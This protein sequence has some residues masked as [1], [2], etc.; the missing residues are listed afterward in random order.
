MRRRIHAFCSYPDGRF[1]ISKFW[2]NIAYLVSTW[3]MVQMTLRDK[4]S[5][6]LM[7]VYLGVVGSAEVAKKMIELKSKEKPS[8]PT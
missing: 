8:A 5:Y 7:L 1:N 4:M 6:E 2:M 3:I